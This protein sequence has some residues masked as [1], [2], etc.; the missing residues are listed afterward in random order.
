MA[1][2]ISFGC[3]MFSTEKIIEKICETSGETPARVKKMISEKQDELS[4]LVSEEGAAYM[5][6]R[7][8]GI[9]LI[10]ES[11]REFKIK[12]IVS[13]LRSVDLVARVVRIYDEREFERNGKKGSVI[14]VLL[15]DET[16]IIRM[17]LWNDET[18]LVREGKLKGG[19]T[20]RIQGCWS[21]SDNRDNPE[22]RLGRGTLSQADTVVEMPKREVIEE[23]FSRVQRKELAD[24]KEGQNVEVRAAIVQVFARNPFF[25]VCPE[26]GSRVKQ[27]DGKWICDEHKEVK[28]SYALVMS[29][30]IDDG[31]GNVRATFFREQAERM[32]GKSTE[33][34]RKAALE[35]SDA[36]AIFDDFPNLGREFIF[37]GRV[38]RNDYTERTEMIVNGIAEVDAKGEAD[39]I[40]KGLGA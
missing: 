8:L 36:S 34:L 4:G 16:G 18:S 37:Q 19:E 23:G 10:Q 27:S 1:C 17:S 6:A 11:R 20:V 9:N 40:L 26:C 30:I 33:D 12:N 24:L 13:G 7:D 14:N 32:F 2:M 15:G 38:R 5:V 35:K 31:A 28:P 39:Q 25:E 21:K 29:G 3:G 22:L